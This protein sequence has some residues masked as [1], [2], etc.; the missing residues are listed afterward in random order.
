MS[1]VAQPAAGGARYSQSFLGTLLMS[2]SYT[3]AM[4][5]MMGPQL[6]RF[7]RRASG[8]GLLVRSVVDE[9][10]RRPWPACAPATWWCARTRSTVDSTSATGR[11]RSATPRAGR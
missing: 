10:P 6:A 4:L 5:E 8:N 3:G 2:P 11:R 9:Q 7:F 1:A